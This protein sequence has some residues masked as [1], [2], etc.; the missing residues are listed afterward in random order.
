MINEE[1]ISLVK[2]A[3]RI[4][5]FSGA[6]MSTEGEDGTPGIPD[7]RSK[8]GLYNN[9]PEDI[10]S[11]HFFFRQ[12]DLFY[13]FFFESLYHPHVKPNKGHRILAEWEKKG[14]DI[15]I[16]TQNI[17]GLHSEAGSTSVIEFHGTIKTAKC[18]NPKCSKKYT[19]EELALRRQEKANFYI[20]DCESIDVKPYIKPDVVLFDEA[21]EWLNPDGVS[22]IR[23]QIW[24][25]DLLVVLGS[26]LKVF[27][28][29]SFIDYK[30]AHIPL[31]IINNERIS[32][33]HL[34]NT[35]AIHR[36]ISTTL[37]ELNQYL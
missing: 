9:T 21:G 5:V 27:P 35:Y 6:G 3:K 32:Q 36:N 15:Q 2:E 28:F 29:R 18:Y 20:C 34:P 14:K 8:N 17:D 24:T 31:V 30:P 13:E 37:S 19:V 22:R 10:L 7:F 11:H 4:F 33:E 12:P 1:V 26:S 16:I 25:A 23:N